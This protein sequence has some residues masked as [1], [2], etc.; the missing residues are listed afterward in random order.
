MKPST[1]GFYGG[2]PV[3]VPLTS[4]EA[5]NRFF[6]SNPQEIIMKLP[7]DTRKMKAAD[8]VKAVESMWWAGDTTEALIA[9]EKSHPKGARKSVLA[10][11]ETKL[12]EAK[13]KVPGSRM[14]YRALSALKERAAE[15]EEPE[16]GTPATVAEGAPGGDPDVKMPPPNEV[17][18][19][20]M[21]EFL[22]PLSAEELAVYGLCRMMG[23]DP[24]D[25]MA[26]EPAMRHRP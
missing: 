4:F 20:E 8:A 18:D 14:S 7:F 11:L 10:A 22:D 5:V 13:A 2:E 19:E 21:A 9:Q 17:A 15:A 23:P 25:P 1:V 24:D 26:P 6:G 3:G 16:K 12:A